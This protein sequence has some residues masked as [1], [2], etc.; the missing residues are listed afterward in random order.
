[1]VDMIRPTYFFQL[2]RISVTG[3]AVRVLIDM[4]CNF[5]I[6]VFHGE[7]HMSVPQVSELVLTY[8]S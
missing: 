8:C 1:M 3:V 6:A 5:F 2:V 4:D 7:E